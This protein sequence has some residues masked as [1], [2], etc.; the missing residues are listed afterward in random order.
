VT[1][2]VVVVGGGIA[3]LS[4]A[5]EL[6]NT[7][8]DV[9]VVVLE[10]GDAPGGKLVMGEVGTGRVDLGPDA[11]VTRRDEALRL[12][13]E[14]GLADELV[15]PEVTG[16]YVWARA[17]LRALPA[18]LALGV[19]TRLGPLATSGICSPAG[20]LR[21]GTD[22][23][24]I[25]RDA[26]PDSDF[27]IGALVRRR[28]GDEVHDRLA[29]PLIGGIHAGPIDSMSAAAV[30]PQLVSASRAGGSLM[31]A[32]RP[33]PPRQLERGE[34]R[35]GAAD[36]ASGGAPVPVFM[37][38]RCG[39]GSLIARLCD[40]L[41][42]RGVQIRPKTRVESLAISDVG[43]PG[44][45]AS[46]TKGPRWKIGTGQQALE[47][48]ALVLAVPADVASRLLAALEP[49]LSGL[50]SRIEYASV[51]ILTFRFDEEALP[52]P[53]PRGTG[54]L[55][56][57]VYGKLITACTWLSRKWA[58][59]DQ[60]GDLL[61]RVSVGRHGDTRHTELS[62]SELVE[63][64]LEDL[65][66]TMGVLRRP[67]EVLVTRWHGAFPQY[68]VGHV[69]VVRAIEERTQRLPLVGLAGAA[70]EGV[71]IPACIASGRRAAGRLLERLGQEHA[72]R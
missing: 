50:L 34:R 15:A 71:G 37:S 24:R 32:L 48:D 72:R 49:A 66:A 63:R 8:G 7:A 1:R 52:A 9:D 19:P 4:A 39:V 67:K 10:S 30:F 16:A 27:A 54:Y 28:L 70:F 64:S 56:P 22:L 2:R 45:D 14:L 40:E 36:P 12:C 61:L 38:L 47:A 5:W 51:A 6:S 11:F 55:V 20:S 13:S 3:G 43:A 23:L 60:G 18:G 35:S 41:E 58:H 46:G 57:S 53:L 21:A 42:R 26:G 65:S 33:R 68:A 59:F 69:D 25:R 31:R 29:D 17:R 62:D 44:D